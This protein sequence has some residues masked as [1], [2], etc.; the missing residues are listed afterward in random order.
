MSA[1]Q[2]MS[3]IDAMRIPRWA[4]WALVIAGSI[5]FV[6][7]GGIFYIHDT[8]G[9]ELAVR[10]VVSGLGEHLQNISLTAPQEELTQSIENEYQ[11]FVTPELLDRWIKDPK[12]APGRL[13][14]STWPYSIEIVSLH[15]MGQT[16]F[17]EGAIPYVTSADYKGGESSDIQSLEE[18]AIVVQKTEKGWRIADYT[19]KHGEADLNTTKG[20]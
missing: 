20:Q 6:A 2:D 17:V 18:V 12:A 16:Y 11:A 1:S 3:N 7:A 5:L 10:A 15:P 13:A 4:R 19:V 9:D 14:S 8:R